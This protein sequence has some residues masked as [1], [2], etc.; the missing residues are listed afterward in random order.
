MKNLAIVLL[1]IIAVCVSAQDMDD[2][3]SQNPYIL[4]TTNPEKS[5]IQNLGVQ[6]YN[7]VGHTDLEAS[8]WMGVGKDGRHNLNLRLSHERFEG[9][10][11]GVGLGYGYELYSNNH[12]FLPY[13]TYN[14]D[15]Q[16]WKNKALVNGLY[17]SYSGRFDFALGTTTNFNKDGY[18]NNSVWV[19]AYY[20]IHAWG[21]A[22]IA[23]EYGMVPNTGN[24]FWGIMIQKTLFRRK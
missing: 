17:Y 8:F 24:D 7:S 16:S 20:N 3:A 5:T 9:E 6:F 15:V 2:S 13:T 18:T 21:G 4:G 11:F 23:V 14:H 19:N 1:S 22:Q 10:N 12:L